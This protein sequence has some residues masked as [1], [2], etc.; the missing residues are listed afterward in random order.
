MGQAPCEVRGH[1]DEQQRAVLSALVEFMGDRPVAQS[2]QF[3]ALWGHTRCCRS[4]ERGG[5]CS[6]GELPA[7]SGVQVNVKG[8]QK[9]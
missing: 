1:K 2:S 3:C 9:W 7:G 4:R 6:Q 5:Q 8:K